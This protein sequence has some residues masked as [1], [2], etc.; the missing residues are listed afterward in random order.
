MDYAK[1]LQTIDTEH[2][3]LPLLEHRAFFDVAKAFTL[4]F[5][6]AAKE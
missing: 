2:I 3:K 4:E 1:P 6:R 5:Y